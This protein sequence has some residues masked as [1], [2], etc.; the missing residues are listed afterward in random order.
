MRTVVF[1]SLLAASAA[2]YACSESTEGVVPPSEAER[3]GDG[4][5]PSPSPTNGVTPSN[6][7]PSADG[8]QV[9]T[10]GVLI[11][12][13]DADDDWIEL[14]NPGSTP[15]DISGFMLADSEKDGGAPKP[16]EGVLFPSG[17]VLAPG[18]YLL[19]QAGGLEDGGVPCPG[20]GVA[21]CFNAEFG[22]SHKDGETVYLLDAT[23]GVA[24]SVVYPPSAAV[25]GASWSRLPSGD[26]S[27]AFASGKRTPGA[28]NEAF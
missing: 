19:V 16:S 4:S 12:E 8:G 22:I 18:A 5:T 3:T 14:L 27:A 7:V 2:A 10:A 26:P 6:P 13:I 23:G 21:T 20:D 9:T 25:A 28:A 1:V 24:G 11:N 15:V 17:T